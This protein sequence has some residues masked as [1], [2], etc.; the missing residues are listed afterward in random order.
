M[1]RGNDIKGIQNFDHEFKLSQYADDTTLYIQPGENS[2]YA[3]ICM[4]ATTR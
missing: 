2:L 1:V 3:C 4:Y